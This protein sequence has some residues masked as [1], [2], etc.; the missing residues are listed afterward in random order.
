[1]KHRLRELESI[2]IFG[3][4]VLVERRSVGSRG[5]QTHFPVFVYADIHVGRGFAEHLPGSADSGLASAI[6]TFEL[7]L[8]LVTMLLM[9]QSGH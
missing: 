7:S 9:G 6:A 4:S 5:G 8:G 1:M 3:D 2:Q